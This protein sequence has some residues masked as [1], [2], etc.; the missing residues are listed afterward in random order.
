MGVRGARAGRRGRWLAVAGA[1]VACVWAKEAAMASETPTVDAR[2]APPRDLNTPVPPPAATTKAAW[3]RRRAELRQ[4]VANAA[5]LL[6]MPERPPLEPHYSGRVERDG[7]SVEQVWFESWPG[8]VLGGNLYRPLGRHGKLPAVLTPHGHMARGRLANDEL[9]S[10]PGRAINFARQ[11]YVVFAYDMT[12]YND[13]GL[14]LDHR[15]FALGN[16]IAALWGVS[17]FGV[18]TWNSLRALDYL[19]SLPDVDAKRVGI[20]GESGGGTQTFILTAL[21]DRFAAAAPVNMI[22]LHMQ[23]GCLCENAPG[24]RV[25]TNN[26]EIGAITAPKP[27]LMVAATG[28]WTKDTPRL[29]G[30]ATK[31]FYQLLGAADHLAWVQMDTGHNYNL[32]SREAV[33]AFFGRWLLND[34]DPSHL[35]EQP[36][37]PEPDEGLRAFADGRKPRE[38]VGEQELIK[39][40]ITARGR[41]LSASLPGDVDSLRTFRD[42]FGP[43]LR[44]CLAIAPVA[45]RDVA[46]TVDG[47]AV[48]LSRKGRGDRVS[49]RL[50]QPGRPVTA[51]VVGAD[52]VLANALVAAGR[53]VLSIEPFRFATPRDTRANFFTCYNRT[54]LAERV[55]DV[56][57]AL[58]WLE[59]RGG[60]VELIGV[61]R[62]GLAALLARPFAPLVT[63]CVA[64]LA[65]LDLR[66]DATYTDDLW[67]PGLR[68]AGDFTTAALLT[69]PGDLC[70]HHGALLATPVRRLYR[71]VGGRLKVSE[72]ALSAAEQ[73]KWLGAGG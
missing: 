23:G 62:A 53:T 31:A 9:F 50:R 39:R 59:G 54:E 33:Y 40:L 60:Q 64:D 13:T 29:E 65:G 72:A 6:P 69:A 19:L 11:G 58:A 57:T 22:S 55:Q 14:G 2:Q 5:G 71:A 46:A 52:E 51:L 16:D 66:R 35:R 1:L 47:E 34:P 25:D 73:V 37:Q 38:Q 70:L 30:P 49:G 21:D 41:E 36:F 10:V 15:T 17:L 18:Q 48:T 26:V 43:A 3:Q 8:L 7:Y 32:A 68:R 67:Q 28:D 44:H 20:T 24:L 45:P 12:G 61:G 63:R 42:R 56:L 27:M 4:Q